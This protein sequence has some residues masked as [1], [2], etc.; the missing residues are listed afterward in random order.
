MI[1]RCQEQNAHPSRVAPPAR[2]VIFVGLDGAD[3]DYLEPL[4]RDGTMPNLARLRPASRWGRLN[5]IHPPLSPLVWT[6]M[7]TGVSPLEHGIL[8][9]TRFSP[10]TGAREPMTSSERKVP[11]IWN[12]VSN[13][14]LHVGLFGLWATYPAEAVHGIVVSNAVASFQNGDASPPPGSVF[15]GSAADSIR[16]QLDASRASISDEVVRRYLPWWT[17]RAGLPT[18]TDERVMGLRRLLVETQFY[19]D[20]STRWIAGAHPDLAIVYFE[21]TDTIGHLFAPYAD[22]KLPSVSQEDFEHFHE[23]PRRYFARIDQL[24]GHFV[25]VAQQTGATLFIASD[26]GIQWNDPRPDVASAAVATAGRWHREQGIYILAGPGIAPGAGAP[27]SVMQ[28]MPTMLDALGLAPTAGIADH[29]LDGIRPSALQPV[30]DRSFFRPPDDVA[31]GPTGKQPEEIA[32]LK[33]LGYIGGSE[34]EQRSISSGSTRTPGSYNN[35]GLIR[36][37]NGDRDGAKQAFESALKIDPDDASALWNESAMFEREGKHTESNE[38]LLHAWRAGL[39]DGEQQTLARA[40]GLLRSGDRRSASEILDL[41]TKDHP[42]SPRLRLMRGRLRMD[43][44]DCS[45]AA[46]EFRAAAALIPDDPLTHAS[47]GLALA[48]LGDRAAAVPEL[49]RSLAIDPNQPEIAKTLAAIQ[50]N[51]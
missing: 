43:Q 15:P 33:A 24:I 31:A 11:A 30:N 35:E 48:C 22:P 27:G 42:R 51:H 34:P 28:T 18:E 40:A 38:L 32:R 21:G 46:T 47:A 10:R 6:S 2:R 9:F 49:Q 3:W 16:V 1:A 23:V 8:D 13:R 25:Y 20:A 36:E 45:G 7:M 19:E 29:P 14:G 26:H 50:N 12:I 41:A 37:Q 44:G 4:M 5:T 39:P 17:G